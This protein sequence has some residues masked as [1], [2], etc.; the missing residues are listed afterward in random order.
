MIYAP[1][2]ARF[3]NPANNNIVFGKAHLVRS[4]F[5]ADIISFHYYVV[6]YRIMCVMCC[7]V[8]YCRGGFCGVVFAW[9]RKSGSRLIKFSFFCVGGAFQI[10]GFSV[11]V[12]C[13]INW[14][15]RV[16]RKLN[17]GNC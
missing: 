9:G 11:I 12:V 3:S 8:R 2:F 7:D 6:D 17:G 13:L 4:P 15:L 14:R 10:F 5:T 16:R 1:S